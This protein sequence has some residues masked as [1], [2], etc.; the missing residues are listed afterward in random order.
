MKKIAIRL[1]ALL[2]VF[3]VAGNTIT[4]ALYLHSHRL[5]D[6]SVITHAHPF[7]KTQDKSPYKHH[8]H[9]QVELFLLN[10]LQL[11]FGG[12]MLLFLL[13]LSAKS[14]VYLTLSERKGY[15]ALPSF[16]VTRPPPVR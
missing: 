8:R 6:G 11:L 3:A 14:V 10:H 12:A 13:V 5:P 4:N 7:N 15:H 2:L 1:I 9:T 16:P